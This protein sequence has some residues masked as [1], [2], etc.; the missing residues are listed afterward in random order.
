MVAPSASKFGGFIGGKNVKTCA[1]RA[2]ICHFYAEIVKFW[3][4][5]THLKL[6]LEKTG[7]QK[8]LGLGVN[9][10]NIGS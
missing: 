2:K 1:K 7:G 10:P 6:F 3:L 8:I 9:A 5:L 4:I